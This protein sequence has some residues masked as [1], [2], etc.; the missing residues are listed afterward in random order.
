MVTVPP[1]S[2]IRMVFSGSLILAMSAL[3][4]DALL[5]RNLMACRVV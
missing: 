4:R 2:S 3:L 5:Q 1:D